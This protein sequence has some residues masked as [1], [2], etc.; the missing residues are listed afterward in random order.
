[1]KIKI[2]L[3]FLSFFLYSCS[4]N[5]N[6]VFTDESGAIVT[7][8]DMDDIQDFDISE[9]ADSVSFVKLETN[10]ECLI[11]NIRKVILYDNRFFIHESKTSTILV[12]DISGKYLYKVGS[13]GR[14]PG[15][16]AALSLFMLDEE[17]KMLMIYDEN[18]K[19][20]IY[21]TLDGKFVKEIPQFSEGALIRDIYNM[22]DGRFICYTPDFMTNN[23]WWGLWEVDSTGKP[24][25]FLFKQTTKYPMSGIV[26]SYFNRL[27]DGKV[28]LWCGDVDD[29]YH[30]SDTAVYKYLTMKPSVK[31][32]ADYP[33]KI[34]NDVVVQNLKFISKINVCE[35]ENLI[36]T[37]WGSVRYGFDRLSIYFKKENKT[38]V[39][40]RISSG[41]SGI[42]AIMARGIDYNIPNQML[43]A[44]YAVTVEKRLQDDNISDNRKKMLSSM[45]S[46][47]EE[48]NPV[49]EIF[50]LK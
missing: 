25:K 1:M 17:N 21:Y 26:E 40:R 7:Y 41:I 3:V 24:G 5:N 22:P 23:P 36:I 49:L 28:G 16:H 46:T 47:E 2:F 6:V 37:H 15:E 19:K 34:R 4:K 43:H 39:T 8:I 13:R 45:F 38:I 31:S 11:A 42:D 29:I 33:D 50:Y 20:M 10:N 35:K 12:F 30:I 14:G 44:I 32:I 48:D 9:L 18:S 27:P